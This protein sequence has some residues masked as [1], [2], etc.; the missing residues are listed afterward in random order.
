MYERIVGLLGGRVAEAL[1]LQDISTGA[2]ND[3]ERATKL[4]RNMVTRWGLSDELG[5]LVYGSDNDEVFIGRDYGHVRNYSEE[6][7]GKIDSEIRKIVE[8]SYEQAL[9]ILKKHRDQLEAVAQYLLEYEKADENEF[10]QLMEG[11]LTV[12]SRKAEE[13]A[14]VPPETACETQSAEPEETVADDEILTEEPEEMVSEEDTPPTD[15]D[16]DTTETE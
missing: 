5:P 10:K 8:E 11:T 14:A 3:M 15:T 4:A 6:V 13:A 16:T 9:D 1:F 7:A 12:E 2:S